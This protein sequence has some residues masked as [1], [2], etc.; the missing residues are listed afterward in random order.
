[1]G[2]LAIRG[3]TR[4]GGARA[5]RAVMQALADGYNVLITPDG[6]RGPAFNV[7]RGIIWL[8]SATGARIIPASYDA[9]SKWTLGSWDRF[10][11]PRPFGK[12]HIAVGE[13]ILV[14]P[15]MDDHGIEQYRVALELELK[16]LDAA[17]SK[18]VSSR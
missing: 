3:S 14:P 10:I 2:H 13:P 9:S 17:S 5:A 16:R 6:P 11:V 15:H 8:A 12:V 18:A 7:Q 1:M 4:R